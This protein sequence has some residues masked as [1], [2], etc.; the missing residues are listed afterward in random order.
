[1]L[2]C[3]QI[4][5]ELEEEGIT[6]ILYDYFRL[7]CQ[8]ERSKVPSK[9]VKV[10]SEEYMQAI[11]KFKEGRTLSNLME[12][13]A[14]QAYMLY[15]PEQM[16]TSLSSKNNEI[17]LNIINLLL[18]NSKQMKESL[19]RDLDEWIEMFGFTTENSEF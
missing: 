17:I 3:P 4:I 7:I 19:T 10:T 18:K 6:K 14:K 11:S 15:T 1:M 8:R 16:L 9:V 5:G 13:V 2:K 12:V